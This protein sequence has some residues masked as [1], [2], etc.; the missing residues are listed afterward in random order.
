MN[1]RQPPKRRKDIVQEIG[2]GCQERKGRKR[3]TMAWGR[4]V[5]AVRPRRRE[6]MKK[7]RACWRRGYAV[8]AG[9]HPVDKSLLLFM[10]LLLAQSAYTLFVPGGTAVSDIDI[11]VRTSAAAIFGYFLSGSFTGRSSLS[12]GKTPSDKDVRKM[13]RAEGEQGAPVGQIGFAPAEAEWTAGMGK[14]RPA[15]PETPA[16]ACLQVGIAAGIGLFCLAALLLFRHM[17]GEERSAA[18]AT[19]VQFR[20]FVSGCVGFLI[21]SPARQTSETI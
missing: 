10:V 1:C 20:D 11:M 5:S 6:T 17:G 16:A 14:V 15:P 13:E 21:G 4:R 19:V 7:L 18:A 9:I 8:W 2:G 3:H 12:Q